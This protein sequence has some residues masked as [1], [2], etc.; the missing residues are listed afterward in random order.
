MVSYMM[1]LRES[2]MEYPYIGKL[3][4]KNEGLVLFAGEGFGAQLNSKGGGWYEEEINIY[5]KDL[6]WNECDFANATREYL[7]NTYGEIDSPEH[8]G[9]IAKL[10]RDFT[11]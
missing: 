1:I 4:G 5:S 8:A 10:A 3:K 9:F 2:K 11:K 6:D 7:D